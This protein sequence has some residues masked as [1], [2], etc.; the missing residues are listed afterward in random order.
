MHSDCKNYYY[1]CGNN[2][3]NHRPCVLHH[4]FSSVGA[5]WHLCIQGLVV[6]S[7]KNQILQVED[8]DQNIKFTATL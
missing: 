6:C 3:S 2:L 5:P 4:F 7:L 1:D 8:W